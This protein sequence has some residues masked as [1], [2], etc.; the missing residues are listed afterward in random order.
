[1]TTQNVT[2]RRPTGE[3]KKNADMRRRQLLGAAQ[4]SIVR[5]GLSRTTLATVADEAGLSQ[6]VA[7]FYYKSKTGLLVATLEDIYEKYE[8]NWR[9]ALAQAGD[10]PKERLLALVEAD[11]DADICNKD[12]L[13]VWY[14][15]WGEQK[16]TPQ[17]S[18]ITREFDLN[19]TEAI[20][21]ICRALFPEDQADVAESVAIW[22]D[23]LTDGYWQR[24]HLFPVRCTRETALEGARAFLARM[25]PAHFGAGQG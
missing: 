15:F 21:E 4:R 18:D 20:R 1:M 2:A 12:S 7:V 16:F 11:F 8:A 14:A 13:S 25:L 17:Y 22:I 10:D 23:M 5:N 19:R 24:M 9:R 6:G 3:R